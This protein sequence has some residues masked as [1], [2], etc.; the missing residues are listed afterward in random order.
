MAS[1]AENEVV[2]QMHKA[3]YKWRGVRLEAG[4]TRFFFVKNQ[5]HV[6][7]YVSQA[8]MAVLRPGQARTFAI[9]LIAETVG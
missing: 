5:Y 4:G 7:L 9:R 2:K 3:G 8:E 1:Q 6:D